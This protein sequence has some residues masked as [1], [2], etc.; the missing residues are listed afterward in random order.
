MSTSGRVL[1]NTAF[2]YLRLGVSLVVSLWT[3]RIVMNTLGVDNF[4]IYSLVGGVVALLGFLNAT[5][6]SSTQRF[7]NFAE[8]QKNAERQIKIFNNSF[9]L[10]LLL[11]LFLVGCFSV[12]G[13]VCFNGLLSLP[14]ERIFAAEVVYICMIVS[15]LMSVVN[16]PYESSINA[17]E[18]MVFYAYVG[19]C[20]VI[21]KLLIAFAIQVVTYDKLI[22][23]AVLMLVP[24]FSTFII[25]RI[26]CHKRYRE[27]RLH[28]RKYY[29]KTVLK[30]L[31][32]FAGWNF[33]S[34]AT[35][36]VT[37]YG[38]NIVINHFFGVVLNAAQGIVTQV[39]GVLVNVSFNALKA[40]NPIIV[41]SESVGQREKMLY[42]SLLGCRATFMILTI[43]SFPLIIYMSHILE[44]WLKEVPEWTVLFCQLQL[45]KICMEMMTYGLSSSIIAHGDIRIYCILKSAVNVIPLIMTILCFAYGM[46]PY[47]MYINWII[48]WG[49]IGGLL[50]VVYSHKKV[51]MSYRDYIE[52]VLLPSIKAVAIPIVMVVIC[53]LLTE[54]V[55][56][57][58]IISLLSWIILLILSW[59]CL[60]T[61][62]ERKTLKGY[63]M[64]FK[65]KI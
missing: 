9:L 64:R 49:L 11:A 61:D 31:G 20:E 40:L 16:V 47:W 25:M 3:T 26:Y 21:S 41:K 12:I 4:G 39:S 28:I 59:F 19:I 32:S 17:H 30:E 63:L 1:K 52:T 54:S 43:I 35:G 13:I 33:I 5:L 60:L 36:V 34:S 23:Y 57:R 58:L 38:F 29:S 6:S 37:L 27:C 53:Y 10:H 55:S 51:G 45:V 8:G 24:P 44:W 48:A 42:V 22:I 14:K 46:Q 65:G 2:L 18:D 50:N 62:T 7:L 56:L 15:T